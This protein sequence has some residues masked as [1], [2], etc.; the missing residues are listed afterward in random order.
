MADVYACS[1]IGA[2]ISDLHVHDG[3]GF[4]DN[5]KTRGS[6]VNVEQHD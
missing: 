5:A 4:I 2:G 1:G 6:S 3:F